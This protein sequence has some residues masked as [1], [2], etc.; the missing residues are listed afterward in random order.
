MPVI[1][2]VEVKI[3]NYDERR[4]VVDSLGHSTLSDEYFE[5]VFE[6]RRGETLRLVTSRAAFK[7]IPFNEDGALTYK[8][9]RLIRFKYSGGT[10]ENETLPPA[11]DK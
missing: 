9:N 5:L 1:D 3:V 2:K 6:T 11:Q 4:R 10:V 7:E 8:R